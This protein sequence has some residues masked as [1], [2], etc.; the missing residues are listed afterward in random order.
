MRTD[1]TWLMMQGLPSVNTILATVFWRQKCCSVLRLRKH[2]R[3][4]TAVSVVILPDFSVLMVYSKAIIPWISVGI[5]KSILLYLWCSYKKEKFKTL[6]P[7]HRK[8]LWLWTLSDFIPI[9][10]T[11]FVTMRSCILHVCIS[12]ISQG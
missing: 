3:S 9:V 10:W 7:L 2:H 12:I 8:S 11:P 1:Y 6:N 4:P 5:V